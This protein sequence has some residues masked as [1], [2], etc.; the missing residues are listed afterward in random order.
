M[1]KSVKDLLYGIIINTINGYFV[2]SNKNLTS[3]VGAPKNIGMDFSCSSNFLTSLEG[4]PESVGQYFRCS[5]N[6]SLL[7]TYKSKYGI[8]KWIK[9]NINVGGKISV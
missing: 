2:C 8:M 9:E 1:S 4:A 3:L 6:P 7:K 5:N